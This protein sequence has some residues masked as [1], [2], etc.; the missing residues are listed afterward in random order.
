MFII[1]YKSSNI[2]K[3]KGSR[4]NQEI[5]CKD[6]A[7]THTYEDFRVYQ[8]SKPSD[9]KEGTGFCTLLESHKMEVTLQDIVIT[10]TLQ[11]SF[12]TFYIHQKINHLAGGR[13]LKKSVETK[14]MWPVKNIYP[15]CWVFCHLFLVILSSLTHSGL[16]STN[17]E[18][19]PYILTLSLDPSF[20]AQFLC[21]SPL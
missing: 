7:I 16:Q 17:V 15:V 11:C 13:T 9:S 21:I 12:Y 10:M 18:C 3:E 2:D 6:T 4:R 14:Y 19:V 5:P 8:L 1:T 20:Q